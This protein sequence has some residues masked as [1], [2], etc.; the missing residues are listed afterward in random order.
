MWSILQGR[1]LPPELGYQETPENWKQEFE[2]LKTVN[3]DQIEWVITKKRELNNPFFFENISYYPISV[4]CADNAI[5][6]NIFTKNF[7]KE[8]IYPIFERCEKV[9]V[10]T[11][12][13]PLLEDSKI[14]SIEKK[15]I[16]IERLIE[17][18]NN[19]KNININIEAEIDS[20][21]LKDIVNCHERIKITYDTGNLTALNFNHELYIKEV[22][23]K[24]TNVH[25]KD[26]KFNYGP[27]KKLGEG[28]TNFDL[29]F[30][31]L[32]SLGYNKTF[33]LQIAR[34]DEGDEINYI[35]KTTKDLRG[36]HEKYF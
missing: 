27:S 12:A 18:C 14:D 34:D 24:I 25:L 11:V 7:F 35:K 26:R 13:I 16:I 9:G 32:S 10:K 23:D 6:K 3:L 20:H 17:S 15:K 22:F 19:F 30:K 29:I 31:T 21:T 5:D 2:S 8:K 33:T 36:I 28:D 4:V 1:L